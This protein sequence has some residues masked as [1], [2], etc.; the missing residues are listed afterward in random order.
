MLYKKV[1]LLSGRLMILLT[2]E[3]CE[4]IDVTIKC[5]LHRSILKLWGTLIHNKVGKSVGY[6]KSKLW[7]ACSGMTH[8]VTDGCLWYFCYV[9]YSFRHQSWH[10]S[11]L[12]K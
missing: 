6:L 7:G 4:D 10:C 8:I 9:I 1:T 3:K 12:L 5:S 2:D 11:V